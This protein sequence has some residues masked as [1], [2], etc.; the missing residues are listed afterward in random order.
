MSRSTINIRVDTDQP[1]VGIVKYRDMP[2]KDW[3]AS[4]VH[5][6]WFYHT[7]RRFSSNPDPRVLHDTLDPPLR[8]LA[9]GLNRLGYTTLPSCSGHHHDA[10]HYSRTYSLLLAD[11]ELIRTCGLHLLDSESKGS[12]VFRDPSWRLPWTRK[13]FISAAGGT[14]GRPEGYLAFK[15][16]AEP[17][18]L[19]AIGCSVEL[20]PG[21]RWELSPGSGPRGVTVELRVLGRN[22]AQQT[23][24]W[25]RMGN[26]L[27]R[28]IP[29][30]SDKIGAFE[31]VPE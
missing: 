1:Q 5:Q 29:P 26:L 8:D 15:A 24:K 16:P 23:E 3:W 7:P 28:H 6:E 9:L 4:P 2:G 18:V 22:E 27:L 25:R 21:C 13:E 11:A 19:E 31:E 30:C 10:A 20:T 14:F 17:E 12:M